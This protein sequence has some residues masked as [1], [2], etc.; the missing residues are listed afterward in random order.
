[1]AEPLALRAVCALYGGPLPQ[2]ERRLREASR[3]LALGLDS[4]LAPERRAPRRTRGRR[5]T[6]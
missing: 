6:R 5:S 2:D 3:T 4:G 1:M